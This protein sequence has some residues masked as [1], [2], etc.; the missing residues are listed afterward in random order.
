MLER[1]HI[2]LKIREIIDSIYVFTYCIEE[3]I[4]D[5]KRFN[6]EKCE[7]L[8]NKWEKFKDDNKKSF[9]DHIDVDLV[10][11]VDDLYKIFHLMYNKMYGE[12]CTSHGWDELREYYRHYLI[13]IKTR[14]DFDY[15]LNESDCIK[16]DSK[17]LQ[18]GS[19]PECLEVID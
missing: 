12:S 3:A 2:P 5:K 19:I 17:D 14:I 18:S 15:Y 4:L 10:T 13:Q 9:N 8:F 16:I 6:K 7:M 11:K 1:N